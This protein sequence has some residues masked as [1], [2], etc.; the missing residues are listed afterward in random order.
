MEVIAKRLESLAKALNTFGKSIADMDEHKST[1][2]Y[3]NFR[4]SVIQRFEYS[5]DGFW[6]YLN[7]YLVAV[8][9]EIK[10]ATPKAVFRE[11]FKS[12]FI[13][14]AELDECFLMVDDRNLTSHAYH[15]PTAE[16]LAQNAHSYHRLMQT[17]L[18]RITR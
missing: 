16:L 2:Y 12:N 15:E 6:K 8:G 4:D 14:Q 1:R 18:D 9:I 11:A 3:E 13:T 17:I 5:I 10:P 7:I